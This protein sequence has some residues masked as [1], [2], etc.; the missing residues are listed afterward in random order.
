MEIKEKIQKQLS[1]GFS[2]AE[3]Y[4]SLLADGHPKEEIDKEI[5]F[6]A[7]AIQDTK[8]KSSKNIWLG[9]LFMVI[10]VLRLAR[11]SNSSGAAS[12]FAFISIF[13]GIA[14]AIYYLTKSN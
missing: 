13:S 14:L 2:T 5:T 9:L 12:T 6:E 11:Y 3:I 4:N 8:K 7:A 10:V 1:A